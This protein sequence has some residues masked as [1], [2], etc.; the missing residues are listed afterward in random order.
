MLPVSQ[1][2]FLN[3]INALRPVGVRMFIVHRNIYIAMRRKRVILTLCTRLISSSHQRDRILCATIDQRR[4]FRRMCQSAG[5]RFA[6]QDT[7]PIVKLPEFPMVDIPRLE[8]SAAEATSALRAFAEKGISQAK[9]TYTKMKTAAEEA[10]GI[11]ETTYANASKGAA[12]YGLKVVEIARANSNA[13]FDFATELL[14]ARTFAQAV[15]ISTAHTRRQIETLTEQTRELMSL[16]QKVALHTATPI[17]DGITT[18]VK[19]AA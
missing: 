5:K 13:T 9:D 14:G 19:K 17:K 6:M 7:S 15:E 3:S 11:M 2:N 10:T 16:A 8:A 18:I 4:R 12:D 1:F